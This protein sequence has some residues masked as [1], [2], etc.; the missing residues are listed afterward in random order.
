MEKI[1][2]PIFI[3][4]VVLIGCATTLWAQTQEQEVVSLSD[5]IGHEIDK[6]ERDIYHLFPDIKGFQSARIVRV[7]RSKYRLD[8][9]CEDVA[10]LK[11]KSRNISADALEL[12]RLHVKLTEDYHKTRLSSAIDRE[13]E[14]EILYRMALKYA[15]QAKY[16]MSSR[17]FGDLLLDYSES[18]Q[19]SEVKEF[20]ASAERLWKTKKAL[21]W[22]GS[23]LDQSGRTEVLIFSGYYGLWLG[24]AI[25][26]FLEAESPQAYSAGLLLGGPLSIL[27]AHGLTKEARINKGRAAMI[28]LGGHLGT[29]QG[30]GWAA[31]SD[32]DGEDVIGM[33]VLGGVAG[34][35]AATLMTRKIDFL[36]GHARLTSSG[37][38]WG[39]WFGLVFGIIADHDGDDLLRDMLIGSDVLIL[40]TAITMKDVRMSKARVRLINLAGVLG[41]VFGFG[42]DLLGEVDEESTAFGIAGLGSVAGLAMGRHLTRNLDKGKDLSLLKMDNSR[43]CY[44]LKKGERTWSVSPKLSFKRHPSHKNK[45][46][47]FIGLQIDF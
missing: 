5:S 24:I 21:F 18:N 33:G 30:I 22:K 38:Q 6:A 2:S 29:W 13:L 4:I 34:I 17:L 3:F 20:H 15:S 25:P 11:H 46:V 23:L 16:N 32:W 41:T 28:S 40:G 37:L 12:T 26:V 39:A 7:S 9:T 10:G 47:P 8:Y 31:M 1:L 14:A 36:E 35:G 27:I 42:I 43:L 45:L 19:A 44:S